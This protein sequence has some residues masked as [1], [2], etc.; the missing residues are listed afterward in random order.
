MTIRCVLGDY[1]CLYQ[2]YVQADRPPC[3]KLD[4]VVPLSS[5]R[6]CSIVKYDAVVPL[7]SLAKR[8]LSWFVNKSRLYNGTKLIKPTKV[9][10]LTT[11]ASLSGWGAVSDVGVTNGIWSQEEKA[12]HIN[13][14]E[15]T[16][17]WL[18]VQ[19]FVL[20]SYCYI[21]VFCDNGSA[22]AYINN[23]GGSCPNLHSV[24]SQIWQWCIDRSCV[25]E[26][27]YIPGRLNIRAD[28]LSRGHQQNLEW[29]LHPTVFRWISQSY[30]TPG[31]DLF[32]S[33]LNH[34]VADYASWQPDPGAVAE[35]AFSL[36]WVGTKPYFFPPFSLIGRVLTKMKRD[37]VADAI[38]I[39]PWW[40]TAHWYPMLVH[41][42][43]SRPLLLPQWKQLLLHPGNK[44]M[45]HPLWQTIRLAAWRVSALDS[46][47][48]DFQKGL[49]STCS[50]LGVQAPQSSIPQHGSVSVAGVVR[51]RKILFKRL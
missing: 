14:L 32:A 45:L 37:Q 6:C 2:S 39:A 28:S 25:I 11:D 3:C 19:C 46:K 5:R 40:P 23:M 9:I 30:F 1:L 29:K 42:I 27:F 15:L 12:Q 48:E 47:V 41:R 24:A 4:A 10:T 44:D 50:S 33:R 21:K 17:I 34:Q 36:N 16:A 31:I 38:I 20:T 22:V 43:F 26:A 13:W 18:G 7:S 51:G 8:D 49:P 35:D